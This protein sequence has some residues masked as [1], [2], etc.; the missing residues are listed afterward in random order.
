MA[1]QAVKKILKEIELTIDEV[2]Y[3]TDSKVVLGYINNESKRFY[4]YV[5]NRVQLI[6]NLSE[7]HQWRYIQTDENPADLA[8][9]GIDASKLA[10]SVWL[11][12]PEVLKQER[13]PE[14]TQEEFCLAEDDTEVRH[15]AVKSTAV[16]QIDSSR[17][18]RFS[19][20]S[21]LIRAIALLVAKVKEHK[22]TR[23][24]GSQGALLRSSI[25]ERKEATTLVIKV[26]QD[27]SFSEDVGILSHAALKNDV[28]REETR[29]KKESLK[30]SRLQDLDPFIDTEGILRVG[31]RLRRSS[32]PSA[33]K[34]PVIL[35]NNHHVS[36]L[37]IEHFHQRSSH[38]GRQITHGAV[39][40]G[41]Y[42]IISGQSA[43]SKVLQSCITCKKSRGQT[44][45]QLM[46]DLPEDRLEP[47][48]PFTNVGMDVFGPWLIATRKL[49]GGAANS[50]RWGLLFTC[51]SS[52]AIHIELLESMDA[53]SF[54]CALRRFTAIRGPVLRIRCDRGTNF[55]GGKSELVESLSE[56]DVKRI[57]DYAVDRGCEW[58]FNPPHA[59]HFAPSVSNPI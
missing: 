39:R 10:D 15:V 55:V 46:S 52:R 38:Q 53:S 42:W 7:P 35:P 2:V 13:L 43:V 34:H 6:R 58:I 29:L 49:R 19:S 31:G 48:P 12:G 17:F 28:S 5:A 50:K 14:T 54:I 16:K 4:V 51:L 27:E 24:E 3:Y 44:L 23:N 11:N 59:S 41:G 9:R 56:P 57:Q 18:A 45:T 30:R 1:T 32:L 22:G 8:T 37:L 40:Q 25:A 47:T 26:I 36:K 33:E 21:S 20:W